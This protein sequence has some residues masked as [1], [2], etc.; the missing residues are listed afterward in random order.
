MRANFHNT[1]TLEA[2]TVLRRAVGLASRRGHAQATPLHVAAALLACNTTLL[3]QACLQYS[4]GASAV[5][6]LQWRALEM[7][8][9]VALN[10]LAGATVQQQQGP[11]SLSNALIAALKRAQAHQRRGC[12]EQQQAQGLMGVCKVEME[13]LVIS[14]LD[15]PSVSRVMRE[16]GFYTT[17]VK[18]SAEDTHGSSN[19]ATNLSSL[20][21]HNHGEDSS[22]YCRTK[23]EH[24]A[25]SLDLFCLKPS[26][27]PSESISRDT[28]SLVDTLVSPKGTNTV[29]V[30]DEVLYTQSIVGELMVRIESGNVPDRLKNVQFITPEVFSSILL[31]DID[32]VQRKLADLNRTLSNCCRS[33]SGVL[34]YVG[35]L[36]WTL[37]EAAQIYNSSSSYHSYSAV[38]HVIVEVGRMLEFYGHRVCLVGTASYATFMQCKTRQPCL[39]CEWKLQALNVSCGGLDLSLHSSALRED[40]K[41]GS[42]EF[43]ISNTIELNSS[44]SEGD[45]QKMNCCRDCSSKYESTGRKE[46]SNT[47]D[48]AFPQVF[49]SNEMLGDLQ[50]MKWNEH[51]PKQSANSTI[52]F[53]SEESD[54][55]RSIWEVETTLTLG[56]SSMSNVHEN[57]RIPNKR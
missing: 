46:T 47:P 21:K 9:N 17:H 51:S 31:D 29:I 23:H 30:G 36:R 1:L 35:D 57:N 25:K 55:N 19:H 32:D 33:N 53:D 38:E 14:I 13:Q 45:M 16:A 44:S 28:K 50:G 27:P 7:C 56:R 40:A 48:S 43:F 6:P 49:M 20:V 26:K 15:D 39:E 4:H 34:V 5:L 11:P 52:K 12:I 18:T 42:G 8:L 10:R 3:R 24:Y 37:V 22:G 54:E 41:M 2:A